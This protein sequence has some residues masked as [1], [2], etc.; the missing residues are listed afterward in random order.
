[1]QPRVKGLELMQLNSTIHKSLPEQQKKIKGQAEEQQLS[2]K[3][4]LK[5]DLSSNQSNQTQKKTS[6]LAQPP[7]L[8]T[9][10][11]VSFH[12][13]PQTGASCTGVTQPEPMGVPTSLPKPLWA[14]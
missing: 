13:A 6:S 7:L 4:T 5:E 11:H 9:K 3:P 12:R 8:K 14:T 2:K 10:K 1:M